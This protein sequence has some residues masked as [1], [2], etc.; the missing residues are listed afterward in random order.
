M[1]EISLRIYKKNFCDSSDVK[2]FHWIIVDVLGDKT[3][4]K[5]DE[6]YKIRI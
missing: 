1:N 5:E 2:S 3:L 6:V 4:G